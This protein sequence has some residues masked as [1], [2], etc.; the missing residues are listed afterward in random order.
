MGFG[1]ELE[2]DVQT[3]G[4]SVADEFVAVVRGKEAARPSKREKGRIE[5]LE[6]GS[7]DWLMRN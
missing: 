4:E 2:G 6:G 3:G 7:A 1:C 5:A